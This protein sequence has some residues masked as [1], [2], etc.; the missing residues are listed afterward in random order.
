[1]RAHIEARAAPPGSRS[2]RRNV[3][4]SSAA[5]LQAHRHRVPRSTTVTSHGFAAIA[6][7]D[8]RVLV[9]GSLPGQASLR[10]RQ[11]YAQPRN[12]FW[13][14]M[15]ELFGASPELPYLERLQIL[16]EHH[17]A[18]WDVCASA[19][20]PGSLDGSIR[21]ASVA[22]NDFAGLFKSHRRV[23]L[24]CF[25]GLTAANLYRRLVL[26]GLADSLQTIQGET[27]PSTSPA[28]AAMC[29][30]EKLARWSIIQR[31]CGP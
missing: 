21:H 28:Y 8:A 1:M 9:L 25:N 22:P 4:K 24:I 31:E 18:L 6:T 29:F 20:R 15:G 11:Y 27:L 30:A 12:A 5:D 14:I 23:G 26:P 10:A 13:R 17:L 2:A 7:P 3:V 19:H 16:R